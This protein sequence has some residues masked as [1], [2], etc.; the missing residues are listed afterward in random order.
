MKNQHTTA[1]EIA[2]YVAILR[3]SKKNV[4]EPCR[5]EL[6]GRRHM[7]EPW[8]EYSSLCPVYFDFKSMNIFDRSRSTSPYVA[9][10]SPY[11]EL[12]F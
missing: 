9:Q 11:P 4:L 2:Q 5:R 8:T 10:W 7:H 12:E 3:S 6:I 1:T